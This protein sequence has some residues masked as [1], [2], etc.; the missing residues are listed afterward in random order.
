MSSPTKVHP[1]PTE[2]KVPD[3]TATTYTTAATDEKQSNNTDDDNK[4]ASKAKAKE[5]A[6]KKAFPNDGKPPAEVIAFIERKGDVQKNKANE[7][8][9]KIALEWLKNI[10]N[11]HLSPEI[12]TALKQLLAV[13]NFTGNMKYMKIFN[14]LQTFCQDELLL[15]GGPLQ[16]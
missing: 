7:K 12:K 6:E 4:N 2:T 1:A 16:K 15:I 13:T 5:E 8:K 3:E 11:A 9:D 14:P 10:K